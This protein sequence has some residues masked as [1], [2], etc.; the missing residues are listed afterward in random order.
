MNSKAIVS[1]SPSHLVVFRMI[2]L[3]VRFPAV[4]YWDPVV[5]TLDTIGFSIGEVFGHPGNR[6][7]MGTQK[8]V[9][10]CML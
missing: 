1:G 2:L 6:V 7:V 8:G 9:A 4:R 10:I 3:D 5:Y